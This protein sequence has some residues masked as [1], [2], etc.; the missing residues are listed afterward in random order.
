MLKLSTRWYAR[1]PEWKTKRQGSFDG[2]EESFSYLG[3]YLQ[4]NGGPVDAVWGFSQGACLAGMLIALLQPC[5]ITHPLRKRLR[6]NDDEK[7]HLKAGII[8]AGFRARFE[9]YDDI[10][11]P[12]GIAT[13]VLHVIGEQ[14]PLVNSERSEALMR[15]C[16]QEEFLRFDGGHDIPKGEGEVKRIV[17]FMRKYVGSRGDDGRE[18]ASM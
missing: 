9:Q 2:I 7:F 3:D 14:D 15:V 6:I 8:F 1:D 11:E 5:Q 13:P 10:Y 16:K 4:E 17:D 18:Q 12:H